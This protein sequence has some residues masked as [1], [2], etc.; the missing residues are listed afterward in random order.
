MKRMGH[1]GHIKDGSRVNRTDTFTDDRETES[2]TLCTVEGE[3]GVGQM[4]GLRNICRRI[5]SGVSKKPVK[6]QSE[7]QGDMSSRRSKDRIYR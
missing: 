7:G 5:T 1:D 4:T 3:R 2:A 6:R